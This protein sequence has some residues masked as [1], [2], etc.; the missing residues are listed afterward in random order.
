MPY[1][2]KCGVEVEESVDTCPLCE[3]PI[4]KM[5][6]ISKS[7][8]KKYPEEPPKKRSVYK[9]S[10]ERKRLLAWEIMS[11]SLLIPLV[12][13]T[14]INLITDGTIKW[15]K[16][17]IAALILVWIMTSIPLIYPKKTIVIIVGEVLALTSFLALIDSFD[18][19]IEWV[20]DLAVPIVVILAVIV[21][22][23]VLLSIK[24][25]RKGANIAA[26][27]ILGIGIICLGLDLTISSYIEQTLTVNWSLYVLIPTMTTALFL[28]YIHYRIINIIDLK[29]RFQ[30]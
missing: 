9:L 11:M 25:K 8:Q 16:Y 21:T 24:T 6:K 26:Y 20:I 18:G 23:I 13:V 22:G 29:K 3:T 1:C 30:L 19:K 2:S 14:I 5:D 7:G 15:A 27:I 28:L 12:S 10:K 17:P 4:Q